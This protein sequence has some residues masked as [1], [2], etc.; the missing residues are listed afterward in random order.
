MV[1]CK[2]RRLSPLAYQ[3]RKRT[4]ETSSR[5]STGEFVCVRFRRGEKEKKSLVAS[6]GFPLLFFKKSTHSSKGVHSL[7]SGKRR[8]WSGAKFSIHKFVVPFWLGLARS[9]TDASNTLSSA[10]TVDRKL[11]M[12]YIAQGCVVWQPA[13]KLTLGHGRRRLLLLRKAETERN[14]STK[15]PIPI[16]RKFRKGPSL[17]KFYILPPFYLEFYITSG[18]RPFC[19]NFMAQSLSLLHFYAF[20]L[21]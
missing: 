12:V 21:P 17:P 1:W 5:V 8:E 16:S 7:F 13:R 2:R 19:I 11:F 3:T 18:W 10:S 20:L 4:G 14:S 6:I 15:F 9:D